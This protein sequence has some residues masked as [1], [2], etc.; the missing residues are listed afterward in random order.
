MTLAEQM[1]F[2]TMK[3][4]VQKQNPNGS[5]SNET[6]TG[7]LFMF[8]QQTDECIRVLVT[9]RHV[10][11]HC[12]NVKIAFTQKD[13]SGMPCWKQREYMTFSASDITFHPDPK[14]DLAVISIGTSL[15]IS[16]NQGKSLMYTFLDSS[17]IPDKTEWDSLNVIEDVIMIGYPF[18]VYDN[19]KNLPLFRRGIT[20]THPSY[21]YQG[22]PQFLVDMACYSGSSGSPVFLYDETIWKSKEYPNPKKTLFFL[23][24]IQARTFNGVSENT[25]INLHI[26]KIIKSTQLLDFIPILRNSCCGNLNH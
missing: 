26:G 18:G 9:N 6:A 4:E 19:V 14:I 20:G 22:Q 2:S 24:G 11:E 15:K 1:M 7:F 10:L 21:D 5:M 13:E 3:I 17:I 23:L 16:E 8:H 25:E 12:K